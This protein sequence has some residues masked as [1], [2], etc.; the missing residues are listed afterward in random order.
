MGPRC[1]QD[2]HARLRQGCRVDLVLFDEY[3]EIVDSQGRA[4]EHRREAFR[5]LKLQG[6]SDAFCGVSFDVD[7]KINYFREWT[8]AADQKQ[9]QAQ[10]T[11]FVDV[12]DPSVPVMLSTE[13]VRV[14]ALPLQMLAQP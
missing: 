14:C 7:E 8:I 12:G 1:R 4:V 13:K 3:I 10:E 9:Y 6:R 2:S 11:D 5:I